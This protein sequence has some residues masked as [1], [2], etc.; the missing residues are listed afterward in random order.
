MKIDNKNIALKFFTTLIIF[1]IT[2]M[3]IYAVMPQMYGSDKRGFFDNGS[4]EGVM[5]TEQGALMLAPA[6]QSF[7]SISGKHVW[8]LYETLDGTMYAAIS[9]TEAALYKFTKEDTNFT[10]FNIDTNAAAFTAVIAD[11]NGNVYAATGP[12]AQLYKYDSKGNILWV[13]SLDDLYIWDMK[14]DSNNNLYL[15]AGG[16]SARVLK[17]TP[18]GNIAQVLKTEEQHAM[19]LYYDLKKDTLYIGTAGRGLVL[20]LNLKTLEYNVLYDTAES[21]VHTITMD[22]IGNIYFGT[23]TREPSFLILPSLIDMDRMGQREQNRAFRN[24]LYKADTNGTVQRLFFLNQNLIFALSSDRENNIYFITGDN[25]DIYRIGANDGLLSYIGGLKNKTLSTFAATDNGL[26]FAIAGTGEVYKMGHSYS[27]T[28]TFISDS[29]DMKLLSKYGVFTYLA[30]MPTN[31]TVMIAAR[32]GNVARVDKTWSEFQTIGEDGKISAPEGRFLQFKVTMTTKDTNT[33]PIIT[34]LGFSYVENNLP[35]DVLNGQLVT[36][37]NQQSESNDTV[38]SPQ[39][40]ENEAML[41]WRGNDP[42]GDEL[43]YDVEYRIRG[44]KNYRKLASN[45]TTSFLK[46]NAHRLPSGI[47]D[48]KITA[49]DRLDNAKEDAL[50]KTLEV[51]NVKYDNEPPEVKDFKVEDTTGGKIIKF[52]VEDNLSLLKAV[53]YSTLTSDWTYLKP[54]DGIVDS[55]KESFTVKI[56]D[57]NITSITIEVTDM[58]GNKRFYSFL[59]L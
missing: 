43:I 55:M 34:S 10:V 57:K 12:S 6:L 37:Y 22:N 46:F 4:Y 21:E 42:N 39:L 47:Y 25:A 54:D 7:G 16:N 30:N 18:D 59:V 40:S 56:E 53:R 5:L 24:S 31:T 8:K 50:T 49:S 14:F 38:K 27:K 19:S 41:W 3:Q 29:I 15:A 44:E 13:K 11:K 45:I 52:T 36:Y 35:P 2:A 9:G 28:G 58:M 23:A 1:T 20:A 32:T 17:V 48:F 51:L 33:T 26:Y